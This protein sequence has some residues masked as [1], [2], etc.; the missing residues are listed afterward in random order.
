MLKSWTGRTDTATVA[1]RGV[2]GAVMKSWQKRVAPFV[3]LAGLVGVTATAGIA[4]SLASSAVA[5]AAT[6][7]NGTTIAKL[8]LANVDKHA[9]SINSLHGRYFGSS[10]TGNGGKPEYWCAD[11]AKWVWEHEGVG[12]TSSLTPAAGSFYTYGLEYGTLTATPAVGDA[13]VFNYYGGGVAEHVAIVTAVSTSGTIETVSGDWGGTGN[14]EA[15]F[16]STSSVV[17]NTPEYP[18]TIGAV[19]GPMGMVLSGFVAPVG[20]PVQPVVGRAGLPP[21]GTITAGHAFAS[22]NG[23]YRLAINSTGQLVEVAG[24]RTIWSTTAG[25]SG[26]YAAMANDGS[27]NLYSSS[28]AILWSSNSGSHP[29]GTYSVNLFN[30][31][32]VTISGQRTGRI[33]S[34]TPSAAALAS[35]ASL[36][37]GE[38]LIS[39]NGLY[40]LDMQRDGNLVEY[41]A[42]LALWWTGTSGHAGSYLRLEANGRALVL[43]ST[44][45]VL[46]SSGKTGSGGAVTLH[47]ENNGDLVVGVGSSTIWSNGL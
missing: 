37:T 10:C 27:F 3:S 19:P 39:P 15:Q 11:F 5:S 26:D 31:G 38:Q 2:G 14:T 4:I 29:V 33:W 8:A 30:S 35:G 12:D 1:V 28:G 34:M 21:S 6:L 18:G 47:L 25:E 42:G 40:S 23:V 43:S 46:W 24:G 36:L 20:V 7:T 45:S 13:A 22:P 16:A 41:S 44:A 9:C 17:E 32:M